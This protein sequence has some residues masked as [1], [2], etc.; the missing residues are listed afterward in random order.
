M[1][2]GRR[3]TERTS[4]TRSFDSPD[5]V[6][7]VDHSRT[8]KS[9]IR[10]FQCCVCATLIAFFTMALIVAVS[11][12]VSND[13][14]DEAPNLTNPVLEVSPNLTGTLRLGFAPG[15]GSY[16]L[17]SDAGIPSNANSIF[18]SD[19]DSSGPALSDGEYKEG[20]E[21]GR[22]AM[23][24]RLFADA[25]ALASP[26]PSPSPASRHRYAVSTCVSVRALALA[27]VAELAATKR[28]EDSRAV[29]GAPSA[30]GSF[31][32][33]DWVPRGACKQLV[34]QECVASKYR[35]FDGSCNRP[36]QWGATMTPFRRVLPPSYSDGVEAPRKAL[37]GSELPSAREV[38]L[39]VH[40]PSPS[41]NPDFTVMLAVYGQFLDHDITATAISQGVNGSSISCCPPSV[42]HPECF[43]VP[44]AS[45]DPVFDVTGRTC[46]EFVRSAGAPQCKIGPRQQLNQVTAFID[47][48]AI[49]GSDVSM[50]RDL[51]EF[52]G[53]RL[54]MQRTPDNRTL[55]PASTNP[56]DGCNRESERLRGRYCFA[57]GDARA[58]ENL[59]LTTMHLLWAR[60]HNRIAEELAKINP[61]WDDETL[62]EESRR[63]VVAQLQ[64]IT[65]QEF[66]PTVLGEQETESR[67]LK[68]LKSGYRQWTEDPDEP[69]NDPTIA[70]SFAAAAFRFAHTLLPGLMKVTDDLRGTSSYVEL[71]RMLF[72][73]YSLYSEGGVKSSVTSATENVVQ[74]T[75][76]H[77]TSQLTNH[78]FEDPIGNATVPC[79]LD[80]VSLN[81]QRGRDHGLPGYTRWREY[82]G[83]GKPESF[84]DLEGHVDP[85]TLRDMSALY[86]SVHDVDLYTG[87]L[88]ELPK[89]GGIVGPTFSCLIA[90]Q[91]V[92]LQKGDRFWYEV[93]DRP[94][95]FSADQLQELRKT[96]LARL[97][98]DCSDGVTQIQP[99]VM[100]SIGPNN[101]M[102]SCEDI[103]ALSLEPWLDVKAS[104]PLLRA[105]F[106]PFDWV[107][108]KSN[109]NKTIQDVVTYI[110]DTASSA[111]VGTDWLAFK[112]YINNSFSDLKN[113]LSGLHPPKP[114]E[115]QS[116]I[117]PTKTEGFILKAGAPASVYM[118]WISFKSD[119][120]KSLNDSIG[121][122][123][124]GPA[125]ATKWIAFKQNIADQF[126]DLKSQIDSMKADVSPKLLAMKSK[127]G[128]V[129]TKQKK[130]MKAT[131]TKT[132]TSKVGE[133]MI[134]AIFDWKNFKD[135][136]TKW[137]NDTILDI[138]SNMPP[139]G[140]PAWATFGKDIMDK[141]SALRGKINSTKPA[142][143]M[144]LAAGG[145]AGNWLAYKTDVIDAMNEA[146]MGIKDSMP[147]P[148]DPAWATFGKGIMDKYSALRGK[149]NS[150]NP[151]VPMQMATGKSSIAEDWLSYKADVIKTINDTVNE[152]KSHMPPPGDPAWATY[153]DEVVKTFSGFKTTPPPLQLA[154]LPANVQRPILGAP[155]AKFVNVDLSNLTDDWLEFKSQLNDSLTRIIQ[156]IQSKKPTG[157]DPVGWVAFKASTA[158][159]FAQLKDEIAGMK[160][161][162]AMKI[163]SKDSPVLQ[164]AFKKDASGKFDYTKFAKPAIPSE[165]WVAFKKEINDTLMN[166]LNTAN[167]TEKMDFDEIQGMFNESFASLRQEIASLKDQ[168]AMAENKSSIDDWIN[169][170]TQLNAMVKELTEN[171]KNGTKAIAMRT[172]FQTKDKLSN[173]EPPADVPT[174]DLLEYTS[175]I[176]ETLA[177]S[178]KDIGGPKKKPLTLKAE[179]PLSSCPVQ[180][181]LQDWLI[182]SCLAIVLHV[183][184]FNS[185][186]PVRC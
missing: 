66:V 15:S 130:S 185:Q 93:A 88:A 99:E 87:A 154:F 159:E 25:T 12:S 20:L 170:Q 92:R 160:T 119:L 157:I 94:H 77:V 172:L 132:K 3:A 127:E 118:D 169:F 145:P 46:M 52:S 158:N 108:F 138:G 181:S 14:T 75:S 155:G 112:S 116:K 142:V 55:L 63:I 163:K 105:T 45:G 123:G 166:F 60:Q 76:T 5:Y 38:S 41:S 13:V 135:N 120:V 65:Y 4:L 71:H 95:S 161:E 84:S 144:Q 111:T 30:V 164:A 16:T 184:S 140:D 78:L 51:R 147:P 143:P 59:H 180:K 126:T 19:K 149:I 129:V 24:D 177:A 86:E 56:D 72:N 40:R 48:S 141:Y 97:I 74:M 21:A 85:Q 22:Q 173:L 134:S 117:E 113:Q 96:S 186:I 10:Q 70:N 39:K 98:C 171:L 62:Y 64:H 6:E 9:R 122:I 178:L 148:G 32:D 23:N 50:A 69:N 53:G 153:R 37:S 80:L 31:F 83:L 175:K 26:L 162:W 54:R 124:G 131:K 133:A 114:V 174:K 18:V 156:D 68:P 182:A 125:S 35:S 36:L 57:A 73:P 44:V 101:P 7:F 115:S 33:G 102:M 1:Y 183:S 91:F 150:T 58:N 128:D 61:A 28:I 8:R 17:F 165:D 107:E 106:A 27:A 137:L 179:E 109:I 49:Y 110:N 29:L 146:V 2:G 139:P 152:I 90:D 151:P 121:T 79:G 11:Y 81:I 104:G 103:P 43:P 168:I 42:G 89:P 34:S 136:I 67:E 167:L 176:S 47:G 82:C 100:R